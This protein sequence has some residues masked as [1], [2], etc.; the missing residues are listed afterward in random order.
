[1]TI[2]LPEDLER[3]IQLEVMSGHFASVDDA[4]AE[5][6]RLLLR[7]GSEVRAFPGGDIHTAPASET[8]TPS[9]RKPIWERAD[10]L[11]KSIPEKE[12]AKLPTDGAEQ[13]DHYIYGSPKR[14]TT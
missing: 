5:A 6:A 8:P 14:P 7:Q 1:M 2:H 13:L 12:W 4:M 3:D 11:R 9:Q 10:E